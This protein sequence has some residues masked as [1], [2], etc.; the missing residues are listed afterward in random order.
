MVL[1][2]PQEGQGWNPGLT[3]ES[4]SMCPSRGDLGALTDRV[5]VRQKQTVEAVLGKGL[6]GKSKDSHQ[7]IGSL[8]NNFYET[9]LCHIK[10]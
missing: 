5:P 3:V 9:E 4:T 2:P 8:Y 10:R 1:A 6:L 7:F